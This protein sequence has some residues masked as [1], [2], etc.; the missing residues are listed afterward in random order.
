MSKP[1]T[2]AELLAENQ[3]EHEALEQFF[4]AL[5]PEEILQ[6]DRIGV[7]SV[8]DTLAHL[9][10]WEQRPLPGVRSG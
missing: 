8:K 4:A 1:T 2:K 7:W 3:K 9:T 10:A 6:G 5:T